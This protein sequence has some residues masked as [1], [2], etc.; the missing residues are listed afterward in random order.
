VTDADLLRRAATRLRD[1]YRCNSDRAVDLAL[2]AAF[3]RAAESMA[4]IQFLANTHRV[5]EP[6]LAH[7]ADLIE[8]RRVA[9]AVLGEPAPGGVVEQPEETK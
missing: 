9:R 1:P 6:H 5:T 7:L 3:E 4:E 8:V 2:A